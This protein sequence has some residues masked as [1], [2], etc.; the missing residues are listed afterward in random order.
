MEI[1]IGKAIKAGIERKK[2]KQSDLAKY[3]Q[4]SNALISEWISGRKRPSSEDLIKMAIYLDIVSEIFQGYHKDV[5]HVAETKE[6]YVT[7]DQFENLN[8][9]VEE[10]CKVFIKEVKGNHKVHSGIIANVST[11]WEPK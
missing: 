9:K 6:K 3:L 11:V 4:K 5:D 1:N 2:I 7:K 10:L 8:A